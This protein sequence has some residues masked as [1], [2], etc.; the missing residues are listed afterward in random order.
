MGMNKQT[1][2][3]EVVKLRL[4][5]HL[6]RKLQEI[7]WH[8]GRTFSSQCRIALIDWLTEKYWIREE[9]KKKQECAQIGK[10][11]HNKRV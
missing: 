5:C 2:P 10:M 6:K 9:Y 8:E 3:T 4:P 7:G 1:D 11:Q